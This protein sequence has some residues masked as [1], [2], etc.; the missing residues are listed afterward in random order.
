MD[1]RDAPPCLGWITPPSQ[2]V[3]SPGIRRYFP[4]G[5]AWLRSSPAFTREPLPFAILTHGVLRRQIPNV[6]K[7]TRRVVTILVSLFG[8]FFFVAGVVILITGS[9][10][11]LGFVYILLGILWLLIMVLVVRKSPKV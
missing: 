5:G 8:L 10:A 1:Y 4:R 9:N 2:Q 6:D 3:S 7:T 11:F